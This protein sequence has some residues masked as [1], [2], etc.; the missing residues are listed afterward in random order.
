[1]KHVALSRRFV[2][3]GAA[4]VG[5]ALPFL[6]A[7]VGHPAL[8]QTVSPKR[9]LLGF[10]GCSLGGYDGNVNDT[11]VPDTV[12][13]G[14]ALKP[15]LAALA[16][17]KEHVSLVTGLRIPTA[18]N[19]VVPAGGRPVAFHGNSHA[20]QL[21]GMRTQNGNFGA[22]STEHLAGALLG[23]TTFPALVVRV[24]VSSY[25]GAAS[26]GSGEVVSYRRNG[27]SIQAVPARYSP[28]QLFQA[29]FG[30]FSP[31]GLTPAQAAEQE[32][33]LKNRKS[34]LDGVKGRYERLSSKLGADDKRRVDD[35]LQ[36]VRELERR[37]GAIPP[38]AAGVCQR[39]MDPGADPA[40]G[41][42]QATPNGNI[43]Y[44]QNLGYSGEE[45]RAVAMVGL[46]HMALS[47]DLTRS[48]LFQFT[49]PQSFLNMS[50]TTGQLSDLHELSH[51]S[52]GNRS[53][54]RVIAS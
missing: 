23:P 46:V 27:T 40:V 38:P 9:Y 7:M 10:A 6:E 26:A 36:E 16:P 34:V 18:V 48:V 49:N 50:Q 24:Q 52:H 14:F 47:C 37:V 12:G 35:H 21:C 13:A 53:D 32:W 3:R 30:N 45:Q 29:L 2:L 19:G 17:V 39:P 5:I 42:G 28:Q 31:S 33:L 51:G 1:M 15:G 8:A 44:S 20:P 11:I 54:A 41:G 25:V 22:P 4:G 43:T